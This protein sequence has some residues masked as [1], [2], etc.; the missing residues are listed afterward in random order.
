MLPSGKG[1]AV[2]ITK[3]SQILLSPKCGMWYLI[4]GN[5]GLGASEN[6]KGITSNTQEICTPCMHNSSLL[7]PPEPTASII[8]SL[9]SIG[10]KEK[11]VRASDVAAKYWT[12]I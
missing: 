5:V 7:A 11:F 10:I 2:D 9:I 4:R 6:N 1:Y 3:V 8:I 12:K